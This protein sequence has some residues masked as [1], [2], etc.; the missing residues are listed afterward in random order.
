M[1]KNARKVHI[2]GQTYHW[3]L[4]VKNRK[5]A[6]GIHTPEGTKYFPTWPEVSGLTWQQIERQSDCSIHNQ[7]DHRLY[8]TITPGMVRKYIAEHIHKNRINPPQEVELVKQKNTRKNR[9]IKTSCDFCGYLHP[10]RKDKRYFVCYVKG[11]CPA[12]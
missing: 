4:C 7:G 1:F 12:A 2:D 9:G 5:C 10:R 3:V 8:F 11:Y 6:V